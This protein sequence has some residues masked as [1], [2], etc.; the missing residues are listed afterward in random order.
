WSE[1]VGRACRGGATGC[2]VGLE[3]PGNVHRFPGPGIRRELCNTGGARW[4]WSA[5]VLADLVPRSRNRST[6]WRKRRGPRAGHPRCSAVAPGLDHGRGRGGVCRI[7]VANGR[8]AV[9]SVVVP[10]YNEKESLAALHAEIAAA[11]Q[12]AGLDLEIFF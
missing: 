9:I 12:Q 7:L 5:R 8:I 4:T 2:R 6:A 1:L 10:V 11:A 3:Q